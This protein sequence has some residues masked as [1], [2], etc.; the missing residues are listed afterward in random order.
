MPSDVFV[1]A[2]S[3]LCPS[4]N[5]VKEDS[6]T[7]FQ[8]EDFHI[9]LPSLSFEVTFR[10]RSTPRSADVT[11]MQG[12]NVVNS[13]AK[14]NRHLSHLII[15]AVGEGDEGVY[16]VSNPEDPEDVRRITLIVRGTGWDGCMKL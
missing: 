8:G 12:S 4:Y 13:R 11:L 10:N 14:L 1:N 2:S 5:P 9:M 7:L 16:V 6:M 15:D 3:F